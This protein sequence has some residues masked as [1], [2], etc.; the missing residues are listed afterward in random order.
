MRLSPRPAQTLCLVLLLSAFSAAAHADFLFVSQSAVYSAATGD[1][2]FTLQF[3]Q[4]PDFTTIDQ[5]GRQADSFQYTVFGDLNAPFPGIFDSVVRGDELHL[6]GNQ[7]RI[8]N[9]VPPDSDPAAGGWGSVRGTVPFMLSGDVLTFTA[10]LSLLSD[11]S[12]D[13]QL[14]YLLNT[15]EFGTTT[16][17]TRSQTTTPLTPEPSSLL[18]LGIGLT[19]T[20]RAIRRSLLRRAAN[21][22]S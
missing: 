2:T 6:S 9:S 21:V 14:T 7:L 11:H 8:R 19:G 10:P 20:A 12:S 17:F 3:N 13:G 22:R 1:V 4:A 18:L 5:F 16:A 15:Y